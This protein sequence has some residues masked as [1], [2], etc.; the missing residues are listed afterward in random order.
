MIGHHV[1]MFA[2]ASLVPL[3][4]ALVPALA[5]EGI[6]DIGPGAD[7]AVSQMVSAETGGTVEAAGAV[8]VIPGGAL[9]GDTL[10]TIDS[11]VPAMTLPEYETV[12]G[13]SYEMGPAGTTFVPEATLTLPV[14]QTPMAGET[15]VISSLDGNQWVDLPTTTRA[16]SAT[17]DVGL[18][19][20]FVVRFVPAQN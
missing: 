13:K 8:L 10:I 7:Q 9:A 3:L 16:T 4:F 5:C 14:P 20:T 11:D 19:S 2:R 17:A 12:R 15:V 18:I 1:H 6:D